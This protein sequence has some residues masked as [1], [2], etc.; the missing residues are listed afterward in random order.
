ME[1]R[2]FKGVWIPGEIWLDQRLSALDKVILTEIDSL[3]KDEQGCWA[4]NEHI[5]EFCQCSKT[6]VS[7]S[8]SRLVKLGYIEVEVCNG[9]KRIL[10][11]LL[12]KFG[13]PPFE[14]RNPTFQKLKSNLSKFE[15]QPF[16]NCKATFQKLKES[17]TISNNH[18]YIPPIIP[19]TGNYIPQGG[20]EAESGKRKRFKK[21]EVEEIRAYCLER[22]NNIDAQAFY[23][24][25]ESKGWVVGKSPMRDWKAAV[26]TWERPRNTGSKPKSENEFDRF[27]TE[28]A[29]LR[30]ERRNGEH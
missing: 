21:P 15:K 28:L 9:R 23:D 29:E 3:D 11:S 30:E 4:N 25:Y 27:V 22:K 20:E 26:R 10:K 17:N 6:T 13:N 7:T 1:E 24:F 12:S 18:E 14:N 5:A 19:L 2:K 8:I 16:K